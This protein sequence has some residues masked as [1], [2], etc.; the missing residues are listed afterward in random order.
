M[1]KC[2]D[3]LY[4]PHR[5]PPEPNAPRS[6]LGSMP[7]IGLTEIVFLVIGGAV[8]AAIINF[9]LRALGVRR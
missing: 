5:A 6:A 7:N 8:I 3:Q 4:A 1:T 2:V 9:V